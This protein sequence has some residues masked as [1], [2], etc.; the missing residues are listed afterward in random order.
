MTRMFNGATLANP[1]VL[2]WNVSSVTNMSGIFNGATAANPNVSLWDVSNVIS[3]SELF[4]AAPAANPNVINWNVGNVTNMNNMFRSATS[5]NPNTTN[6]DVSSVRFMIN[7]FLAANLAN[8]NVTNWNVGNVISM[9]N[10]FRGATIAN[11]NMRNWNVSNVTTM[12]D[13]LNG[14]NLSTDNLDGC[15]TNW[16]QLSL[17][18]NVAFSAGTTQFT[19]AAQAGRNT[20]VNTYNWTITDGGVIYDPFIIEVDTSKAG[21]ANDQFQFTGAVG[22]YDVIAKQGGTVVQTFNN[23]SNEQTITFA[24]GVGVYVLEV[25]PNAASGFNRIN[26]NNGGDKL[27]I[28]DIKRWG[29][30]VWSNFTSSFWGCSNVLTTATDAPNLSSVTSLFL[31][32]TNAVLINPDTTNWD[33]SNVTNMR[34]LFQGATAANPNVSL[35]DVSSVTNMFN[36]FSQATSA[37]PDLSSWNVSSVSDMRNILTNTN[38]STNNLDGCYTNW[39]QL[40]LQQNVSFNAGGTKFSAAAQAGRDILVNTYNWTITDG[41]LV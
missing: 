31:M 41:G 4:F 23:L 26:F 33:V 6:W 21:S 27:K 15:Y 14:A 28:T 37:N 30:I 16:S 36:L 38:L 1:N 7:M 20:L 25:S 5:A 22:N 10:M 34:S 24:N 3:M 11:P 39:S 32:F 29:G 9:V 17:Q 35:W 12:Q 13:M 18:S 19:N 8:P 2:N 40:S